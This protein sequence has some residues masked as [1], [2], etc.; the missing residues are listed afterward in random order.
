MINK[1]SHASLENPFFLHY[2]S[3]LNRIWS[4]QCSLPKRKSSWL[5]TDWATYRNKEVILIVESY[6]NWKD[7]LSQ[8]ECWFTQGVIWR[9]RLLRKSFCSCTAYNSISWQTIVKLV[10][11]ESLNSWKSVL[12]FK[13]FRFAQLCLP[14]NRTQK[15]HLLWGLTISGMKRTEYWKERS[16]KKNLIDCSTIL[17]IENVA[18]VCVRDV[19]PFSYWRILL[20]STQ[21]SRIVE[22]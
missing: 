9:E 5:F 18:S 3:F 11:T 1:T 19:Q 7:Y 8:T 17:D 14:R 13:N 15:R 16:I 2:G 22:I 4:K 10:E 20:T 21:H 6:F 12:S